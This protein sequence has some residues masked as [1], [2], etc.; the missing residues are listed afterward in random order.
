MIEH[1]FPGNPLMVFARASAA[2]A[3]T[4]S[5]LPALGCLDEPTL[6]ASSLSQNSL[7]QNGLAPNGLTAN[8][9]TAN[10]VTANALTEG[11][12]TAGAME[13]PLA[14]ERLKYTRTFV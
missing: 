4:A 14:R 3:L 6:T 2:V 7:N 13:D 1:L 5:A 10:G 9:L 8:G 12:L 11:A